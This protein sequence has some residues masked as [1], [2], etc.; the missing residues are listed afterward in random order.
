MVFFFCFSVILFSLLL[1]FCFYLVFLLCVN[2]FFH[3]SSMLFFFLTF[4]TPS[5]PS[6]SSFRLRL[7]S[8][9]PYPLLIS[10]VWIPLCIYCSPYSR[11]AYYRL[12]NFLSFISSPLYGAP[13][14]PTTSLSLILR[15]YFLSI[16]FSFIY[17]FLPYLCFLL[18]IF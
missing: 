15:L 7:S 10:F 12:F 9:I 5:S 1:L 3:F 18:F 6:R 17:T 14:T 13:I 2:F 16:S 8:L 11:F 4:K